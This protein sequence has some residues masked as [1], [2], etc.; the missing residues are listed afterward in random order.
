MNQKTYSCS[1]TNLVGYIHEW[2]Q[3]KRKI[4]QL[5]AIGC[6]YLKSKVDEDWERTKVKEFWI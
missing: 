1:Y 5:K 2:G 3:V 4:K 6:F